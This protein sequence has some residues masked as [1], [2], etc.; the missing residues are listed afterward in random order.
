MHLVPVMPQSDASRIIAPALQEWKS[1]IQILLAAATLAAPNLRVS[2]QDESVLPTTH[3]AEWGTESIVDLNDF[4]GTIVVLDFFAYWC[5]PCRQ[6][7]TAVEKEIRAFYDAAGGNRHG[8]PVTVLTINV[9]AD[10]PERTNRFIARTGAHRVLFDRDANLLH[11]LGGLGLPHLAILKPQTR[12]NSNS[13]SNSNSIAASL[14]PFTI[15]YSEPGFPGTDRLR[16]IIDAIPPAI[17]DPNTDPE[18]SPSPIPGPVK[19]DAGPAG[20]LRGDTSLNP[21]STAGSHRLEA[22]V[23]HLTASDVALTQGGLVYGFRS[24]NRDMSLNLAFNHM[25]VEFTSPDF[26]TRPASVT[27][28]QWSVQAALR[29]VLGTR[30]LVLI[31][32]GYYDGFTDFRS[33][34]LHEYYRQRYST[35]GYNLADPSGNNVSAGFRFEA[36]PGSAF[37]QLNVGRFVDRIAPS[38]EFVI[39][40]AT[41]R[42]R[43]IRGS[44]HL[45]STT[46]SLS[47]ENVL[48]SRLRSLFDVRLTDTSGR[49][50][51]TSARISLN[52]ALGER[53]I[54]RGT[55]GGTMEDPEFEAGFASTG[56]EYAVRPDLHLRTAVRV[57]RDTGEIQNSIPLSSAPPGLDS[58]HFGLGIRHVGERFGFNLFGGPVITRYGGNTSG[59]RFFEPLYSDRDWWLIQAAFSAGF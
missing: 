21:I 26:L 4:A 33:A 51:R 32:G 56:I 50:L 19:S 37:V 1:A 20:L 18:A 38:A 52:A 40:P 6:T 53:W 14:A 41:F 42:T 27:E 30:S 8:L 44:E 43:L 25:D 17:Q 47:A 24:S 35:V 36:V 16:E 28:G 54:W 45:V 9:E 2:A 15:A 3:L 5:A 59:T 46:V 23:E 13:N 55:I 49:D 7:T 31:S 12:S 29:Q 57:Y 34:W 22:D 10:F 11:E 48:T 58:Y 39:D